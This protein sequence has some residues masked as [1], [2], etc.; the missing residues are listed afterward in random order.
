M[1]KDELILLLKKY[2][3]NKSKLKLRLREKEGILRKLESIKEVS[4]GACSTGINNDIHSKNAISDKVGNNATYNTDT[5]IELEQKL[6]EL[7]S[8]IVELQY[9]VEE[10]DIRL[11]ALRY[12]E[13]EVLIAYY[14]DDCTYEDIGNRLYYK[15]FNQTRTS[16]HIQRLVERKKEIKIFK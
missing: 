4:I 2:K 13:R 7:E 9:M 6:K 14:I 12:K 16:R 5:T 1:S 8:E 11:E 10:V 15:W 3:E